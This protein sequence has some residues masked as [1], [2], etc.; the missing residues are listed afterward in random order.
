M[1]FLGIVKLKGILGITQ[2][3]CF[4]SVM[5]ISEVQGVKQLTEVHTLRG[6]A[7]NGNGLLWTRLFRTMC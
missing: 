7:G 6:L 2:F 5:G 4:V 1:L 3:S